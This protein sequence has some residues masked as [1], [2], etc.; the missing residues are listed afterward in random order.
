VF[1]FDQIYTWILSNHPSIHPFIRLS[2][3]P[4][5]RPSTHPPTYLLPTY[6]LPTCHFNLYA[7]ANPHP[8]FRSF[9]RV[10]ASCCVPLSQIRSQDQN[11]R[12]LIYLHAYYISTRM[13]VQQFDYTSTYA[14]VCMHMSVTGDLRSSVVPINLHRWQLRVQNCAH[15]SRLSGYNITH[16]LNRKMGKLGRVSK[17]YTKGIITRR[18]ENDFSN[19]RMYIN[20]LLG[21]M[22]HVPSLIGF[23]G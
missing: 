6:Y 2:V 22:V 17:Q 9:G 15:W 10:N 8:D 13:H 7:V 11:S 14:N 3:R 12:L 1:E 20:V 4:S 23:L 19:P 16:C 18:N 21:N 5:V